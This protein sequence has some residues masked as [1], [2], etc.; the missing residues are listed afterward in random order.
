MMGPR[1]SNLPVQIRE[2]LTDLGFQ[3]EDFQIGKNKVCQPHSVMS[4]RIVLSAVYCMVLGY[5]GLIHV[6]V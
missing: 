2:F 4:S 1:S 3:N 5:D 6:R